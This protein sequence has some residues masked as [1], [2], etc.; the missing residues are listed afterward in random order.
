MKYMK[1]YS[2]FVLEKVNVYKMIYNNDGC[3]SSVIEGKR[4]VAFVYLSPV[5]IQILDAHNIKYTKVKQTIGGAELGYDN[6]VYVI[7]RDKTKGY[8]LLNILRKHNGFLRD[9][10]ASDAIE[11][12]RSL[13][14]DDESIDNYI[15]D[16]YGIS[17]EEYEKE[18]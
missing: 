17:L 14:Y 11:F 2:K 1:N 15:K 12:G 13:E 10:S 7:Y 16:K 9:K 5:D 4:D 18:H 3:I 8:H 6:N